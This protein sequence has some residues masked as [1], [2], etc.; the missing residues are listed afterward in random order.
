M[1]YTGVTVRMRKETCMLLISAVND[2]R[3]R[4]IDSRWKTKLRCKNIL[5]FVIRKKR[6]KSEKP[7]KKMSNQFGFEKS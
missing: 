4:Q 5:K 6:Q 1:H 7:K 3:V 2:E